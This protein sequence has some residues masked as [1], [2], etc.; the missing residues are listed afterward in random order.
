[1]KR[2]DERSLS[3]LDL[4]APWLL[5]IEAAAKVEDHDALSTTPSDLF[6]SALVNMDLYLLV[7]RAEHGSAS[8]M[9]NDSRTYA[10]RDEDIRFAETADGV[11]SSSGDAFDDDRYT[12]I[13][14]RSDYEGGR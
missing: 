3:P 2:R 4:G 10:A 14:D 1:M 8:S 9:E 11:S 13:E 5:P 12:P 7:Q 6:G